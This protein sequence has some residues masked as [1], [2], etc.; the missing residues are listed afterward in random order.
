[1]LTHCN[2]C[3]EKVGGQHH[4]VATL[5]P[6]KDWLPVAQRLVGLWGCSGW[7]GKY[8]PPLGFDPQTI[9][10]VPNRYTNYTILAPLSVLAIQHYHISCNLFFHI[11]H[12]SKGRSR[13][14]SPLFIQP[15]S[16]PLN[17]TA[18]ITSHDIFIIFKYVATQLLKH[19][20]K[21]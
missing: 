1:M 21:H 11:F 18:V 20:K 17:S 2:R 15:V 19:M 7:H 16:S 10:P 5:V 3:E 9:Q 8:C 14:F 4:T 6:M 12:I 13:V